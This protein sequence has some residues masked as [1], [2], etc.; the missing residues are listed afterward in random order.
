M[1]IPFAI[2][3]KWL[4]KQIRIRNISLHN[5]STWNDQ[6]QYLLTMFLGVPK[7][8]RIVVIWDF[9]TVTKA[10][11]IK[12]FLVLQLTYNIANETLQNVIQQPNLTK[13][14]VMNILAP[15]IIIFYTDNC[16]NGNNYRYAV[17]LNFGIINYY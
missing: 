8:W 2:S 13:Y 14:K 10:I 6:I 16:R 11:F 12:Q 3:T 1:N 4:H 15:S 9:T 17:K 7:T 5:I